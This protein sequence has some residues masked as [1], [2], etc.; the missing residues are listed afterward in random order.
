MIS[1]TIPKTG[2]IKI[3]T[4]GCPKNQKMCCHKRAEPP[5]CTS[6]K[7]AP[8]WR[9]KRTIANPAVSGGMA[10]R[11]STEVQS[12]VQTKKGTFHRAMPGAA[13]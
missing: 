11:M 5:F 9:S 6:K 8:S 10:K 12:I 4:S 7:C 13:W 3:Y 2:R 1:V